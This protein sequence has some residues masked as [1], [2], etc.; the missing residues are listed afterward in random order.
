MYIY[1][2]KN[3]RLRA[4]ID[5]LTLRV[6]STAVRDGEILAAYIACEQFGK[7][8]AL[9]VHEIDFKRTFDESQ[10]HSLLNVRKGEK[11]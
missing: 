9:N 4:K 11:P 6:I 10:R 1:T 3:E 7:A 5:E 8:I 2:V